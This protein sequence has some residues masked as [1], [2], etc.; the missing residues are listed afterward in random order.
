MEKKQL[1]SVV[2]PL[3]AAA[4]LFG[5]SGGVA[6]GQL[7]NS[8]SWWDTSGPYNS[9]WCDGSYTIQTWSWTAD[10]NF[11]P[12]EIGTIKPVGA[13]TSTNSGIHTSSSG[14]VSRTPFAPGSGVIT[15]GGTE[16]IVMNVYSHPSR[17]EQCNNSAGYNF[18]ILDNYGGFPGGYTPYRSGTVS[19]GSSI[20][21][22]AGG[23]PSVPDGTGLRTTNGTP[24]TYTHETAIRV[25]NNGSTSSV[26]WN[27]QLFNFVRNQWYYNKYDIVTDG[28]CSYSQWVTGRMW[29]SLS[30]SYGS[31]STVTAQCSHPGLKYT[32]AKLAGS[33]DLNARISVDAGT[34]I[35]LTGS[36]NK[37]IGHGTLGGTT[38]YLNL[39]ASYYTL[40]NDDDVTFGS[41][42]YNSNG[43]NT[44]DPILG[45]DAVFGINQALDK[46]LK[47]NTNGGTILIGAISRTDATSQG[48]ITIQAAT[49]NAGAPLG[50]AASGDVVYTGTCIPA[51]GTANLGNY[52]TTNAED[53]TVDN[54]LNLPSTLGAG[55][56][57]IFNIGKK[58]T[59]DKD[60]DG[61][62]I[63]Q[64]GGGHMLLLGKTELVMNKKHKFS[65]AAASGANTNLMGG[66]VTF[67]GNAGETF[68]GDGSG[69]Y[70]VVAFKNA[71][72]IP[73]PTALTVNT[74]VTTC[75][76]STSW[77]NPVEKNSLVG[78]VASADQS[79]TPPNYQGFQ[80]GFV[81]QGVGG[82]FAG[83]GGTTGDIK[84][85][86]NTDSKITINAS[87]SQKAQWQAYHDILFNKSK[88]EWKNNGTQYMRWVAGNDIKLAGNT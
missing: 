32:H 88:S 43:G 70:T 51:A 78:A 77:C 57:Q 50:F 39:P 66:D 2:K 53:I 82:C 73:D 68:T 33:N 1:I 30:H 52:Q 22:N 19:V 21:I 58:L 46:D 44:V 56:L 48:K 79:L 65:T 11:G 81:Y 59:I 13:G 34:H 4:L 74:T 86:A 24:A 55:A 26:P 71:T 8:P 9:R 75:T 41:I 76:P 38:A 27:L 45:T 64:N 80:A 84:Y 28:T 62:P 60:L 5:S 72:S 42:N 15:V 23:I 85:D 40:M 18:D 17:T 29:N 69:E 12:G 67:T 6:W 35:R 63:A 54:N 61:S 31:P 16:N 7:A 87:K 83:F 25:S 10:N 47:T 36:G 20:T 37:S 49:V 14:S 3:I